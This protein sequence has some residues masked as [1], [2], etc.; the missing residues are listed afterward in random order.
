L[1]KSEDDDSDIRVIDFGLS[2]RFKAED[3]E[4]FT[5]ILGTPLYV[6]PEVLTGSYD[7]RCDY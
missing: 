3:I 6:A 1:F 4:P 2:K 7:Y 5:K